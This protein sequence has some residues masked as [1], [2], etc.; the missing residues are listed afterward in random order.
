MSI[1]MLR[2]PKLDVPVFPQRDGTVRLGWRSERSFV[3]TP[4]PHVG[5]DVVLDL[6]RR[7]DGVHS[8][9][10]TIWYA[11]TVGMSAN[12]MS[13]LLAELGELGLLTEGNIRPHPADPAH[14]EAAVTTVHVFG[15][16]P[17]ADA[18]ISGSNPSSTVL[19]ERPIATG[20]RSSADAHKHAQCDLALLTDDMVPDPET[21]T[22]LVRAR[23]PHLQVRL[24]DG[25]G[26]VGPFVL[27]GV[28]SCLRCAD[29]LRCDLDSQWPHVAAQLLGRVGDASR[30]TV[31]AVA[32]MALAQVEAFVDSRPAGLQDT[33]V[34][35]DLRESSVSRRSWSR[36]P[37]CDCSML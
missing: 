9:A 1:V 22:G 6:L 26:I 7:L 10:H 31:L 13:T 33:T 32:A 20:P 30:P 16:G 23:I 17:I 28:S 34:E 21:V 8:R 11:G 24:R 19:L 37:R 15:R 29:L 27:P 36:H 25:L 18:I 2:R 35:I 14:P 5:A 4:P 3:V 12:E